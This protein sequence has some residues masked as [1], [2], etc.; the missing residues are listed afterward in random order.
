VVWPF[1]VALFQFEWPHVW[2]LSSVHFKADSL[3]WVPPTT[4]KTQGIGGC[5]WLIKTDQDRVAA[6]K[7][8]V[9]ERS[10][11]AWGLLVLRRI[12]RPWSHKL[13]KR[14]TGCLVIG[15]HRRTRIDEGLDLGLFRVSVVPI[16]TR[17]RT[18]ACKTQAH[19]HPVPRIWIGLASPGPQ[20][21]WK[22]APPHLGAAVRRRAAPSWALSLRIGVSHGW[23]GLP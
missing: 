12:L 9:L 18:S 17:L 10:P 8:V 3:L 23:L 7:G 11:Q 4:A 19:T 21:R 15:P 6:A 2:P 5:R 22:V 1:E 14:F 13:T 16:A 20:L